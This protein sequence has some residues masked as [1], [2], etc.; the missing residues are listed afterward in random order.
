MENRTYSESKLSYLQSLEKSM[1]A[2][3]D[4]DNLFIN[5]KNQIFVKKLGVEFNNTYKE[6][7]LWRRALSLSSNA[8]FLLQESYKKDLA[9]KALKESAEIYEYLNLVTKE[10]DKEYLLI[11]SAL[12]Y[13]IAGYQANALCLIRDLVKKKGVYSFTDEESNSKL[14]LENYIVNHIQHILLKHI[15]FAKLDVKPSDS[16]GM[17]LFNES[18]LHF[19]N[20]ILH[21][22][23]GDYNQ[24]IKDA[25]NYFLNASNVHISHLLYLLL[26]RFHIYN[27][28]SIW[29]NLFKSSVVKES[30]TW[31]KYI[32]LL[33]NDIYNSNKIKDIE[34]RTSK[35]EFWISQLRAVEKGLVGSDESFVIQMPTSAGKTF[36]AELA[37]MDCL[38]KNPGKKC[39]YVAPFRALT[40]EKELELAENLS[41]LGYSISAISGDYEMDD[42][43]DYIINSAD[44][45][46]ATPE[47]IDL[48]FRMRP[49]FFPSVA[50]VVVDEGHIIGNEDERACLLEFLIIRL[51]MKI[52]DLR[53]IFISAVMPPDNARQFS[54]WL[55]KN[56]NNV[57]RSNLNNDTMIEWEPTR[58]I[59]GDFTWQKETSK[60]EYLKLESEDEK[61][62]KKSPAFAY[63]LIKREK[64]GNKLFPTDVKHKSETAARI[65]YELSDKGNCLIFC[66]HPENL[67]HVANASIKLLDLY[68]KEGNTH[69]WFSEND[70][71]ESFYYAEEWFGAD[72]HITKCIKRGIGVHFGDLPEAIR[73]SV[74]K[75]YQAGRLR[76]LISTNTIGQGL[77][78]PIKNLII[79]SLIIDGREGLQ[80]SYRDFWNIIG[81]AG[82]AGKETEGQIIFLTLSTPDIKLYLKYTDKKFIENAEST[83]YTLLSEYL[84]SSRLSISG[85]KLANFQNDLQLYSESYL[86]DMLVEESVETN[87]QQIVE[88]I[89][90]NSLF[91]IQALDSK[92]NIEPVRSGFKAAVVNIRD[93]VADKDLL[94]VFGKTGFSLK[95]SL[96][97][98]DYISDNLSVLT[99]Y[100]KGDDY[101]QMLLAI[102]KLFDLNSIK[103]VEIKK[104]NDL[105]NLASNSYN[106]INRWINGQSIADVRREWHS[107]VPGNN[108]FLVFFSD[109]LYYR[110]PWGITSFLTILAYRL[111]LTFKEL[112]NEIRNLAG[113]LKY[114]INRSSAC[115]A[116]RLGIKNRNVAMILADEA[117][118]QIGDAFIKWISNL[119]S[120]DI[121]HLDLN[122]FEKENILEIAL[123]VN[124]VKQSNVIPKSF[125]FFIKG[126]NYSKERRMNSK[127]VTT[128]SVFS[129]GREMENEYDPFAIKIL[130]KN[131]ELGYVPREYAKII[132]TEI[133]LNEK[134]YSIKVNFM[135]EMENYNDIEVEMIELS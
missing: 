26:T 54:V 48:L 91:K 134:E 45:L 53:I 90:D 115:T 112:P 101:E 51:R 17:E 65:A 103:E 40:N 11:L 78:F 83:F 124:P 80:I 6:D 95:S 47:K 89:I 79:H 61:S 72:S 75:D 49:E 29:Q 22:T 34:S 129:Y 33:T 21:G 131:K 132:A 10:Y 133:D 111:K 108:K 96:A 1:S 5:Y 105:D 32:R 70:K 24:K 92:L 116:R 28:R 74:E 135:F 114:G 73:R 2:I 69:E 38:V 9:I 42:G 120:E 56:D 46:I 63:G 25:Y 60:I 118:G 37:I 66:S 36:I 4:N 81:R 84:A 93:R 8:C 39:I 23:D 121:K 127:R 99:E 113:F 3:L 41:K 52:A 12:C 27:D 126:I 130:F 122:D 19:Y 57:V 98:D 14:N 119:D 35:F 125:V 77:N 97:I 59:I 100:I 64:I 44:V 104:L 123:K 67:K 109:A 43:Q 107:A 16:F 117:E 20:N 106:A 30:A 110:Y 94:E 18:I 86:L 62:K 76:L 85:L 55:N 71:T 82:R 15:P 58:K 50:L 87:D 13:D 128:N 7:Y 31:K 68:D 102:L 88:G